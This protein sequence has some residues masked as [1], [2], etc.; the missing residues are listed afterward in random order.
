MGHP[1]I[2]SIPKLQER[3][4]IGGRD[5]ADQGLRDD[6]ARELGRD[7]RDAQVHLQDGRGLLGKVGIYRYRLKSMLQVA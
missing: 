3:H 5:P 4:H 6:V 7:G 1:V 2:H